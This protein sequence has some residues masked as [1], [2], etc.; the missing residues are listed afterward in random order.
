MGKAP[1]DNRGLSMS[2]VCDS[3]GSC[4]RLLAPA[5]DRLASGETV[6]T[7]LPI[8]RLKPLAALRYSRPQ[9]RIGFASAALMS[10]TFAFMSAIAAVSAS[11]STPFACSAA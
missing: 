3:Y 9:G 6:P 8:Y 1:G 10:A 4:T 5:V 11:S 7:R 2:R